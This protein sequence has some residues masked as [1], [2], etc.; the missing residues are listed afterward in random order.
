MAWSLSSEERAQLRG[1]FFE[2]DKE[3]KGTV[4]LS[5][6]KEALENQLQLTERDATMILVAMKDLDYDH[7]EEVHYSDLLAG[8]LSS[9]VALHDGLLRATFQRFDTENTGYITVDSLRRVL[10]RG[11]NAKEIVRRLDLDE[12]GRINFG[13]F[14]AYLRGEDVPEEH[15]EAASQA[16]DR[17][18]ERRTSGVA[19]LGRTGSRLL[20]AAAPCGA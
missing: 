5:E 15:L 19:S 4:R 3:E 20:R 18:L 6:L 1:V 16:I 17:E 9:R 13:E 7:D 11:S 12:D 2:L 14:M 10:G 8:T